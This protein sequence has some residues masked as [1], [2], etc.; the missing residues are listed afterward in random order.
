MTTLEKLKKVIEDNGGIEKFRC[1]VQMDSV[2]AILPFGHA[3]TSS[4]YRTWVECFID[5]SV[6]TIEEGYKITLRATD[7]MF[8]YEHYYQEDFLN[9]IR[10]GAIIIKENEKQHIEHIRWVEPLCGSANLIHEADIIV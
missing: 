6:Y 4:N 2:C 3:L 8:S 9:D 10:R 1:F 5:E 7:P